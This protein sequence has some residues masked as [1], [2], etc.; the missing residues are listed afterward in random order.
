[1]R[2]SIKRGAYRKIEADDERGTADGKAIILD[3]FSPSEV[4][5]LVALYRAEASLPQDVAFAMVT[6][7]SAQRRLSEVLGELKEDAKNAQ[8]RR[9]QPQR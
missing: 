9:E 5:A 7:Q 8:K 4:H 3:G 1:M 2:K 6:E